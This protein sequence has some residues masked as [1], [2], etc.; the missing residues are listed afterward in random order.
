M[1]YC[2]CMKNNNP[3]VIHDRFMTEFADKTKWTRARVEVKIN[4]AIIFALRMDKNDKTW[5]QMLASWPANCS[6]RYEWF[7]SVIANIK[8][9]GKLSGVDETYD[10]LYNVLVHWLDAVDS[11]TDR[12]LLILHSCDLSMNKVGKQTG[13]LRQTASR[14]YTNAIDKLVWKLNHPKE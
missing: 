11:V 5:Q 4:S 7:E 8:V 10:N 1:R 2:L 6:V 13:L 14:R 9:K 12:K 3:R